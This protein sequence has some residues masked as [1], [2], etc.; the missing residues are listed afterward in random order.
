M[1]PRPTGLR[2]ATPHDPTRALARP[3]PRRRG[4]PGRGHRRGDPQPP[5]AGRVLDRRHAARD[6]QQ[7]ARLHAPTRAEGRST[8]YSSDLAKGFDVPIVHVNADDPEARSARGAARHGVP[9]QVRPRRRHRPR[10]LPPLRP[11]RGRRARLHAAAHVRDDRDTIRSCPRAIR[12]AAG[13]GRRR[14][15]GRRPRS[16]WRRFRRGCDRLHETA[17]RITRDRR[18]RRRKE[19]RPGPGRRGAG[20]D[21][22]S[23]RRRSSA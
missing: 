15:E 23:N 11:Q 2:P 19:R 17:A 9:K 8:R 4:I 20:R 12:G 22:G 7:P 21:G 14:L 5:G 10:G 3:D 16:S 6:R 18:R 13:R 1:R